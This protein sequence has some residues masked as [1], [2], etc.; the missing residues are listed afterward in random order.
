M[1]SEKLR[2]ETAVVFLYALIWRIFCVRIILLHNKLC[3]HR[4][5]E[6]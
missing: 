2:A 4:A 5:L 6:E 3:N 1:G